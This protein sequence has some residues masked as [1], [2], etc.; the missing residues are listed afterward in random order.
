MQND[1]LEHETNSAKAT[2]KNTLSIAMNVA[3][4]RMIYSSLHYAKPVKILMGNCVLE[5]TMERRGL[6]LQYRNT[7]TRI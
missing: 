5:A 4:H 3:L 6:H 7:G 1:L 2:R